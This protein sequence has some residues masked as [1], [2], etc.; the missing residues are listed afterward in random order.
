MPAH[1][2]SR[3]RHDPADYQKYL[4]NRSMNLTLGKLL[5]E[6]DRNF[7]C[8]HHAA[9]CDGDC[10]K[11]ERAFIAEAFEAG[12]EDGIRNVLCIR[13]LAHRGSPQLNKTE[14][15]GE[16]G[17]CAFEAGQKMPL[18]M[19]VCEEPWTI[20]VVHRKD[21]PCFWPPND[22]VS[23]AELLKTL[24]EEVDNI[25]F[26]PVHA[27]CVNGQAEMCDLCATRAIQD[28]TLNDVRALLDK[29][30]EPPVIHHETYCASFG[31][32]TCIKEAS[33]PLIKTDEN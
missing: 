24:R 26:K 2:I 22:A 5:K 15:P 33:K 30:Q 12:E 3:G 31:C 23:R 16:C 19:C 14:D 8:P 11:D 32:T 4:P 13:C 28:E 29:Y 7:P 17:Q 1:N 18:N 27:E 25:Q 9:T 20:G 10:H 6:F 21:G